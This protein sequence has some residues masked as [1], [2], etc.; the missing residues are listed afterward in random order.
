MTKVLPDPDTPCCCLGPFNSIL[1]EKHFIFFT[2]FFRT[3]IQLKRIEKEKRQLTLLPSS[4]AMA[5]AMAVLPVP[6]GPAISIA[7][8]AIFFA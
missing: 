5:K 1:F 7:R 8:P 4:C 3:K 2:N 6:G